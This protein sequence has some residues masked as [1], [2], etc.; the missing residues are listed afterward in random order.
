MKRGKG[1]LNLFKILSNQT[2]LDILM[3]LRE[4]CL[5]AS[6]VAEKLKIDLSTACR[7]LS[8]MVES[9]ILNVVK[10]PSGDRYDFSSVRVLRMLEEAVGLVYEDGEDLDV[11]SQKVN[12]FTQSKKCLDVRGQMC[13][14]PEIMTKKELEKL[15]P[16]E[17]LF[18]LC[19][20]PLSAERITSF[21]LRNGYRLNVEKFGPVTKIYISLP[22][23]SQKGS[24]S[25]G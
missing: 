1:V 3:L 25:S 19:D 11:Q 22:E 10:T 21:A 12:E 17:T 6:E 7:Y 8:Q 4:S 23:D 2:R 14:V 24:T 9:G 16:G 5:T 13:P 18:V 20:Y 15:Q